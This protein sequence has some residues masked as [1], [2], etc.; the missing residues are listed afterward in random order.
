MGI[1][2]RTFI[3]LVLSIVNTS[4]IDEFAVQ[5]NSQFSHQELNS[6]DSV[7][8]QQE[9]PN[10][11]NESPTISEEEPEKSEPT[12]TEE[13]P[14]PIEETKVKQTYL[15]HG[16]SSLGRSLWNHET[17]SMEVFSPIKTSGSGTIKWLDYFPSQNQIIGV[18]KNQLYK[19]SFNESNGEMHL[20]DSFRVGNSGVHLF[21]SS[22]AD[23]F[24]TFLTSYT[25]SNIYVYKDLN[26]KL[27]EVTRKQFPKGSNTHSSVFH[28]E[29]ETVWI[30]NSG[31]NKLEIFQLNGDQLESIKSMD[32]INPR[33]VTMGSHPNHVY[34]VTEN[35]NS[36]SEVVIFNISSQNGVLSITEVGRQEIQGS[37]GGDIKIDSKRNYIIATVRRNPAGV[38]FIPFTTEGKIDHRRKSIFINGNES[39]ALSISADFTYLFMS[40]ARVFN[41]KDVEV[42]SLSGEE[43]IDIKSLGKFNLGTG[44]QGSLAI[45]Q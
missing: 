9:T 21:V 40:F 11:E 20:V 10:K 44:A 34:L 14:I 45:S 4:C 15:F 3:W 27:S 38:H 7:S 17:H 36:D 8:D 22:L 6:I 29:S 25:N 41:G 35:K 26:G 33:T 31:I 19:Y 30:A 18:Q 42:F 32:Y 5:E 1:L 23:G 39:R 2:I 28:K 12:L 13:E 37:N 24:M 43:E 16:G